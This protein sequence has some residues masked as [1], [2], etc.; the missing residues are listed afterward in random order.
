MSEQNDMA[1]LTGQAHKLIEAISSA[2]M[3]TAETAAERIQLAAQVA[4]IEQRMAAYAAVLDAIG[5]QRERLEAMAATATGARR[6]LYARQ[7]EMLAQQELAIL[8][9]VEVPE[10]AARKAVALAAGTDREQPRDEAGRYV[11]KTGGA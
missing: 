9:R 5:A 8:E 6:A 4:R 11:R 3:S 2:I 7:I 10:T 1:A